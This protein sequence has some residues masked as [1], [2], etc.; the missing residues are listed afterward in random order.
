MYFCKKALLRSE[1]FAERFLSQYMLADGLAKADDIAH[2]LN[3]VEKHLTYGA[4][5]DAARAVGMGLNVRVLPP[6][7]QL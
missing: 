1:Q 5:I 6:D 4:V 2:E 3:A 7:D